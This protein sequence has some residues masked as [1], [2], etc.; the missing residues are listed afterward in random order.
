MK[1]KI[2]DSF[3]IIRSAAFYAQF[4][5]HTCA[6]FLIL[7][8]YLLVPYL[9]S[10]KQSNEKRIRK[11]ILIY[12]NWITKYA[13]F[14]FV[15]VKYYQ[16]HKQCNAPSIIVANHRSASDAF[17]MSLLNRDVVMVVSDWP[18]RIPILGKMARGGGYIQVSKHSTAEILLLVKS[19]I[20]SGV[21]VICFPEGTRSSSKQIGQFHS[22]MFRIALEV[23]CPIIPVCI[24]GNENIPDKRFILTPGKIAVKPLAPLYFGEYGHMSSFKLKQHVRDIIAVEASIMDNMPKAF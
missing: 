11:I 7:A 16:P 15:K 23:R 18:F 24:T 1:A 20:T 4:V 9:F 8:P 3:V 19:Y 2:L 12:G 6:C 21:N 13:T 14:P 10:S 17:L 22:L 5:I